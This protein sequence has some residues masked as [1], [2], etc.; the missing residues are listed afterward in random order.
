MPLVRKLTAE[1]VARIERRGAPRRATRDAPTEDLALQVFDLGEGG[2]EGWGDSGA[3]LTMRPR[4][5]RGDLVEIGAEGEHGIVL[6][7]QA[8]PSG[9]WIAVEVLIDGGRYLVPAPVVGRV[10][11]RPH[12]ISRIDHPARRTY[13]WFV[14]VGYAGRGKRPRVSRFFSDRLHGGPAAA[15]RAAVAFRDAA[16]HQAPASSI[17]E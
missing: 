6:A 9:A 2:E 14:R 11:G 1:E 12:G 8:R 5:R 7:V 13:G 3:Y 16:E 10:T 15:L 17:A 4:P